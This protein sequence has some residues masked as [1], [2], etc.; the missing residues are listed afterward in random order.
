MKDIPSMNK[1]FPACRTLKFRREQHGLS[2]KDLAEAT[3]LSLEFI[4]GFE[5]GEKAPWPAAKRALSKFFGFTQSRLFPELRP[6]SQQEW[7][8]QFRPCHELR[9]ERKRIGLTQT[10]LAN[11]SGVSR[12]YVCRFERGHG[13]PWA[14]AIVAIC[15]VLKQPPTAVFPQVKAANLTEANKRL[16]AKKEV[17]AP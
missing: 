8:S 7:I 4:V 14:A 13:E 6:K 5:K 17:K 12:E 16:L 15:D 11:L 2:T 9:E 10:E 1:Q 3:G